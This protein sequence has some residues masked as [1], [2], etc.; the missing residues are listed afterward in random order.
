MK[1]GIVSGPRYNRVVDQYY[2]STSFHAEIWKECLE[3]FDEVIIADRVVYA[4][5]VETG[6]K[7]VLADGITFFEMPSFKGALSLGKT[8]PRMFWRAK[9]A[10]RQADVW[11]LHCPNFVSLCM[12]FWARYYKVPYSVELRGYCAVNAIYLK[13]RGVK[14][15]RFAA[16]FMRFLLNRQLSQPLAIVGVSKSLIRDFPPGNG[17]PTFAIS[18]NRVPETSYRQARLWQDDSISR[19]IVSL[20]SLEAIKNPFG[21]IRSLHLLTQKGFTNWKYVWIGDGPLKEQFRQLAEQLGLSD[22]IELPGFVPWQDVFDILKRADL[23]LLY[24]LSEGLPR[25]L[26]EAMA[27]ALPAIASNVGGVSELLHKND[28]VPPLDDEMLADKLYEVITNPKRLTEMS[29]RNLH[30]AKSYSAENMRAK[31]IQFYNVIRKIVDDLK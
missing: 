14:F 23:Y 13:L 26:L 16:A 1:L 20:G 31:K 8:V 2:T 6:Q 10:I 30:S 3:V 7:P 9:K 4:D 29:Q 25:A 5:K 18:D 11:H 24:S 15:P 28:I 21:I 22:R 19:T 27:C 17:C 12:W